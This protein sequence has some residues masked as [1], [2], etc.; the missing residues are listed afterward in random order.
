[1]ASDYITQNIV[2]QDFLSNFTSELSDLYVE[3]KN[4]FHFWKKILLYEYIVLD[5]GLKLRSV[6]IFQVCMT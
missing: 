4:L 5:Y 3:L 6:K 2:Q 1:M